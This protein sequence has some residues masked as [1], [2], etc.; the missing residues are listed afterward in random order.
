MRATC[1][2]CSVHLGE[3]GAGL[4]QGEGR[5]SLGS[6]PPA[7]SQGPQ[8]F[9]PLSSFSETCPR[10]L[11]VSGGLWLEPSLV[12]TGRQD[13]RHRE[14]P[15]SPGPLQALLGSLQVREG[16]RGA[17]PCP[18]CPIPTAIFSP[19]LAVRWSPALWL[20]GQCLPHCPSPG[21]QPWCP[22]VTL[23]T[24]WCMGI[25][26]RGSGRSSSRS[27][28]KVDAHSPVPSKAEDQAPWVG[29]MVYLLG[30]R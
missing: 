20:Q 24:G 23:G 8:L 10:L 3:C 1:E 13:S 28:W 27:I 18:P 19:I 7:A 9:S 2:S 4:G 5:E 6:R 11:T 12:P 30:A 21:G 25:L 22:T 26:G 29:G 14:P 15:V 17:C 16:Y